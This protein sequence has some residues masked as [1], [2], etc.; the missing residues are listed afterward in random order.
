MTQPTERERADEEM[1]DG[2]LDGLDMENPEPS[3]NRSYSYRHGFLNG[4]ADR[5]GEPRFPSAEVARI[6]AKQAKEM[7]AHD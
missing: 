3:A 2:Y 4:R 7:D 1:F 6:F 5:T